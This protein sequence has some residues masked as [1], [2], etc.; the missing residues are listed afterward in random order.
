MNKIDLRAELTAFF[1]KDNAPSARRFAVLCG[2][3]PNY[4]SRVLTG[5]I[6]AV[7]NS[8]AAVIRDKMTMFPAKPLLDGKP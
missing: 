4:I 2:F 6:N 5:E 3:Q 1:A 8:R 7:I